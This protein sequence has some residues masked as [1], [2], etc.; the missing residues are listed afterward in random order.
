LENIEG[1]PS[2]ENYLNDILGN[3]N[4]DF[5]RILEMGDE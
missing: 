2:D 4:D 1:I 3:F 5:G